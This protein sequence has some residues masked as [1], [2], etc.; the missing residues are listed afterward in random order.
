MERRTEM[1]RRT[2]SSRGF[3]LI[4]LLVVIAIIAILASML[5]PAL[6]AAK[7]QAQK[8]AC[9]NNEKQI[10]IAFHMYTTD[11]RD[12]M[13]YPNW[14]VNNNGWLYAASQFGGPP[15]GAMTLADYKTGNLWAYTGSYNADHRQVYWCPVDVGLTNSLIVP[16]GFTGAGSLAFAQRAM[17]MSTYTMNGALMGFKSRPPAVGTPPQGVTHK[18]G[19][20]QPTTALYLWEP[21]LLDP[22][23]SYNDGSN[24]PSGDQGPFPLH[25]GNFPKNPKGA[26]VV[27]FDGHVQYL[28]GQTATN[29]FKHTP[30][31]IWCDPDTPDGEGYAGS[32]QCKIW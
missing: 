16:P 8:T 15:T 7:S 22:N 27:G 4:E 31:E 12:Y 14:G 17:Q 23:N 5:L 10:G 3:T 19:S 24:E 1:N 30:G 32:S 29:Y 18:L 9:L 28:S 20:I 21:N 11:S 26:N 6:A 13:V 25:G 2:K